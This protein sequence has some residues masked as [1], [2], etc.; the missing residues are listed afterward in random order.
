M[1]K[2][3]IDNYADNYPGGPGYEDPWCQRCG[4]L[5]ELRTRKPFADAPTLCQDCEADPEADE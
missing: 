2:S 3:N 1:P 4:E 5:M